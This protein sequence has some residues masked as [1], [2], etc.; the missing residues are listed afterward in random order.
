[1]ELSI[2]IVNWNSK[3]Y[4]RKCLDSIL[5]ETRDLDYEIIVIDSASFDGCA[6]MIQAHFPEVRF[7]QS[8]ENLGFSRANNVA[9]QATSGEYLLFLNPDTEVVGAAI[10]SLYA[11]LKSLPQAGAIG[12]K[13]LNS[14]GTLQTSCVQAFPTIMNQ[15]LGAEALRRLAPRSRL[16]GMSALFEETA[17]PVEVDMVSGAC[18]MMRRSVFKRIGLFSTDYFMYAEDVDLCYKARRCGFTNYYF[19]LAT[20]IHHGGGSSQQAR[21]N[22]S[23]IMTT[24][25]IWKFLKTSRG[26]SYCAGYRLAVAGAALVRVAVLVGLSPGMLALSGASRWSASCSKWW[27]VF[28][29]SLGVTRWPGRYGGSRQGPA[30]SG[31]FARN[32]RPAGPRSVAQ[33]ISSVSHP[34]RAGIIV[35]NGRRPAE[36]CPCCKE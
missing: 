19:G 26:V 10:G 1:M 16:W 4:V 29:W 35:E 25:S 13:L 3:D 32:L 18:L 9:F 20:V 12:C 21:S 5:A 31:L 24:E 2:I 36:T 22:F 6:E 28:L 15:I 30:R 27:A 11:A 14:D 7:I 34:G 8:Q 33:G 23:N 17:A